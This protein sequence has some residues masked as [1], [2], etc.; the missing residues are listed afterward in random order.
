MSYIEDWKAV[1]VRSL[2][3]DTGSACKHC[4]SGFMFRH[5]PLLIS[6]LSLYISH[7]SL[8]LVHD[9]CPA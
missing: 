5:S 7:A 8:L 2:G 4:A 3:H 9:S 1:S 6:A